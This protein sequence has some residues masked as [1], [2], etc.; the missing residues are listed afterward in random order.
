M[1]PNAQHCPYFPVPCPFCPNNSY[2]ASFL[3]TLLPSLSSSRETSAFSFME[4]LEAPQIPYYPNSHILAFPSKPVPHA[5]LHVLVT[6]ITFLSIWP[7]K[8]LSSQPWLFSTSNSFSSFNILI[9]IWI[10]SHLSIPFAS[11]LISTPINI[12][13]LYHNNTLISPHVSSLNFSPN[14]F[15]A[16]VIKIV[17]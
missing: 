15:F 7:N 8:K 17:Q 5:G 1:V 12:I 11:A 16:V 3:R 4:I 2:I 13:L 14:T 9:F 6:V 10:C